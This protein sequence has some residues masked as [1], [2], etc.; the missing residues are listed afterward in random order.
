MEDFKDYAEHCFKLFGG[1]VKYWI[2]LNEPWIFCSIGYSDGAFAP[3]RCSP[4]QVGRCNVGDS[5]REPYLAAHNQLLA[6]AA[7]VHVYRN[8]Y[9]AIQK[10]KIGIVLNSVW[11]LPY[12]PQSKQDLDA[13]ERATDFNLGWFMEPITEGDYPFIMR[14]I[15]EDRLPQFTREQSEM[16]KG[17]FDFV[18]LNYYTSNYVKSISLLAKVNVSYA[19]DMHVIQT[20]VRDGKPIGPPA[21]SKWL[22][23]YP[24]GILEL[25]RYIKNNYNNPTIYVT[26]NGVDEVNNYG[27]KPIDEL[28]KDGYRI[29]YYTK[30]LLN[31]QRAAAE[32]V[33]VIG[34]FAW[35]MFDNFEWGDG[36]TALHFG[37][38]SF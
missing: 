23:S 33:N 1:R 35:S 12:N 19:S 10:G 34:F 32:G 36:Y 6:H 18:G 30:H 29:N 24:Q 3:G 14:A 38:R 9:Q 17:S 11:A 21:A 28:L 2:T 15:V 26:E 7:A 37:L 4:S 25:L 22:L 16:L 5:S 8:K 27:K 13:A 20:G 31:V